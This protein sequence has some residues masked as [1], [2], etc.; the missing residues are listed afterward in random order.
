MTGKVPGVIAL[1]LLVA[2]VIAGLY[3]ISLYSVT[4]AGIAN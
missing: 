2:S 4:A 1:C 3:G